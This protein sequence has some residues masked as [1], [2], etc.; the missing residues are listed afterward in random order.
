MQEAQTARQERG[1]KG[2][3]HS[4]GGRSI[5]KHSRKKGSRKDMDA[6]TMGTAN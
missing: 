2:R 1:G 4:E 5:G 6:G 3:E